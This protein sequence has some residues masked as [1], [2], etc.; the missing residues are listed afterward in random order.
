MTRTTLVASRLAATAGPLLGLLAACATAPPAPP[1]AL[2]GAAQV[3]SA[4]ERREAGTRTF[5]ATFD[6]ALRRADG[7]AESSRGAVSVARPDRLR[8]Q[9]FSL[10]FLTAYDLTVDG[11]R[12]RVRRPL[13]GL[14]ET[15]RLGELPKAGGG[16]GEALRPLFLPR[17]RLAEARVL[18]AGERYRVIVP[19]PGGGRRE[20]EV[21]KRSGRVEHETVYAGGRRRLEIDYGDYRS[22]DGEALPFAIRV[23]DPVESVSLEIEVG[24]YTRNEPVDP[25]LFRF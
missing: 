5:T 14:E 16:L 8:L 10:G 2:T 23:A 22:V 7:S 11:E 13:E 24:H 4:L 17:G 15:G 6:V 19:G 25:G 3:V 18:D 20:I 9:I 12:F 1:R 21:A